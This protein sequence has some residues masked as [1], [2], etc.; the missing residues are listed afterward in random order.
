MVIQTCFLVENYQNQKKTKAFLAIKDSIK[1]FHPYLYLNVDH[2][3]LIPFLKRKIILNRH[4]RWNLFLRNYDF[5]LSYIKGCNN[6]PADCMSRIEYCATQGSLRD[7]V[8]SEQNN[9]KIYNHLNQYLALERKQP[10]TMNSVI[11]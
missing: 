2:K 10:L 4:E 5:E 1:K 6:I 3:P 9:L 11:A 8:N 7:R